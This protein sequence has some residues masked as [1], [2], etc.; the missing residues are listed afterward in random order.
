[1][2]FRKYL[3]LRRLAYS[4]IELRD[5]ESRIIDVAFKYGVCS[6]EAF[7]RAFKNSYGVAPNEYRKN[8][9]PLILQIK[10]NTFDPYY[11]EIG[12]TSMIKSELQ[13][14]TIEVIT[15]P[16]HKFLHVKNINADNY[17]G[18]WELQEKITGQGCDTICGLLDSV[19]E[20]LD[21]VTGKIGEFDGQI[22]G[23]FY[24]ETGK[25]GYV[26]GIR[27]PDDYKG[28]LPKQM[29]CTDAPQR[30]YI[31]F[32]HPPFDYEKINGSVMKAVETTVQNYEFGVA[33]YVHDKTAI[34]YQVHS[35]GHLGYKLYI[36]VKGK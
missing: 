36:P 2:T 19:S 23:N 31:V 26:Y 32:A 18:F 8:R 29:I 3:G 10:P 28:V 9:I 33:G 7:T 12:E 27:M 34:I 22:G 4:V 20:K 17:F 6:Q 35:P 16:A 24:D 5:T 21:G 30:E 1:M 11:L 15:L 13:E 14:V 25:K